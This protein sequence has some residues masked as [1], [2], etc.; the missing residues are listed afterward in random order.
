MPGAGTSSRGKKEKN[1]CC[2]K[3]K[4]EPD[5]IQKE[6][7]HAGLQRVLP[8]RVKVVAGNADPDPDCPTKSAVTTDRIVLDFKDCETERVKDSCIASI[9]YYQHGYLLTTGILATLAL[10]FLGFAVGGAKTEILGDEI[11]IAGIAGWLVFVFHVALLGLVVT[12]F[13]VMSGLFDKG[14][15]CFGAYFEKHLEYQKKEVNHN[16]DLI[17]MIFQIVLVLV[18]VFG[19]MAYYKGTS[20]FKENTIEGMF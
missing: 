14:Q 11:P 17:F 10:L 12:R 16:N 8:C 9:R 7:V 20:K 3:F 2:H 18:G 13:V 1:E 15:D 5:D 19:W 6:R 4:V